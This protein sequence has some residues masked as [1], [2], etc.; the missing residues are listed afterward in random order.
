M[1]AGIT[2][3]EQALAEQM[4]ASRVRL[5]ARFPAGLE[6]AQ[7]SAVLEGL[8]GLPT[9]MELV[10][11]IAAC[12]GS[13]TH[14]LHVPE[15]MQE[16]VRST[17]TGIIPSLR[18]TEEASAWSETVTLSLR[19]FV[20]ASLL[21]T[22]NPVSAS[23]SLLTGLAGL[24]GAEK[25]VIRWALTPGRAKPR[26]VPVPEK[27][28]P[29]QREIART[30]Q[31]K[32]ATPAFQVGG[33]ALIR[34]ATMA[35]AREL[36]S[37]VENLLRSRRGLIGGI[38]VTY[39]RG[40]RTLASLPKVSRSSGALSVAELLPL[41]GLP[42][43]ADAVPNVE[44]GYRE[45]LVPR[46]IPTKG[47]R[48]LF[49]GRDAR[50][51]RPVVLSHE[52]ATHHVAVVGPSGVGKSVLI[53]N[54]IL[55][56]IAAH[57]G[58]V[59]I[60]PKGDLVDTVLA[61][62]RPEDAERIVVVDAGDDARPVAGLDVLHGGDP[63]RRAD[64]LVR[65]LK[66]MVPEW[67]I[68]SELFGRLGIRTLAEVPGAT[69]LDLGRLFA[70]SSYRQTAV[71]QLSDPF[72]RQSWQSYEALSPAAQLDVIQAPMA[73][74][75]AL[76]SRP[77]VRAVVASPEP[78]V[79][80]GKLLAQKRFVLVSLAPGVLGEAAPLIGAAVMLA[81]WDAIEERVAL[82]PEQRHLINIFIDEL[83]TVANGLPSDIEL[84][85]E[86]ARGLGVSLTVA[87]QT[88]GRVPEPT[89]SAL[90]G[91]LATLITFRA[92]ATEAAGIARELP[93]ISADDLMALGRF[94]V[95][96]RVGVG[97][98]SA[99]SVVTGRTEPLPPET[100]GAA[101]IRDRS[102]RSYGSAPATPGPAAINHLAAT[103][104]DLPLG[105]RRRR[106]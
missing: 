40:S 78:K 62:V 74:I 77:R 33:L 22:D 57:R 101:D 35:R 53:A 28:T 16:S 7:V 102:A 45:L 64:V 38:R 67:G 51:E 105:S 71:A 52:A 60:D 92:A 37:H 9:S 84:V 85:A 30:W 63:D 42:L 21:S 14:G 43:G 82:P 6:A 17:L 99:V 104:D 46:Q 34:A 86:R 3:R 32:A 29:A 13:I 56:E 100:G 31:A 96:A 93:G 5:S 49:V 83:A 15:P 39:E 90:L 98:G 59:A 23:R 19:L 97:A 94:E 79:E 55:S 76:L 2:V 61:R 4:R 27:P 18:L 44:V 65:T 24:R 54:S 66:A 88:L 95:A 10:A 75:M 73:R 41:L 25:V 47:G 36:A 26:P 69:L 81:T 11:E 87:V 8:A 103:D 72:L 70:D 1:L 106:P 89:R 91:N 20:P 48:V 80:I 50:G 68:R 58:G 12:D